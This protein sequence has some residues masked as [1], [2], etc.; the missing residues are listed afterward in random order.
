LFSLLRV[1]NI[2]NGLSFYEIPYKRTYVKSELSSLSKQ[3]KPQLVE[4][5]TEGKH[6]LLGDGNGVNQ[7]TKVQ[8]PNGMESDDKLKQKQALTKENEELREIV[9]R[10]TTMN[11]TD[12]VSV[13]EL[14]L[15]VPK[16]GY[17]DLRRAMDKSENLIYLI[18]DKSGTFMH[19]RPD[20]FNN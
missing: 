5:S 18:F 19:T 4:V 6:T 2:S 16:S 15:I 3:K 7:P 20:I 14:E 9:P 10:Q 12:H 17:D 1:V 11:G 8:P 13:S